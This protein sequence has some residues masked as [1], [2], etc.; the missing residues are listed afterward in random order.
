MG[1]AS[2]LFPGFR[3]ARLP[4]ADGVEI[5]ARIG[6]SGPPL[7]MLHGFPQ[8]HVMW[9]R[10][11]PALARHFTLV[12]AD[13]RGQSESGRPSSGGDAAYAKRAMA[14]DMVAVM[15][16]LGF[17]RFAA[18]GH[19]RGGR[20]LHRL[21]LD[22]PERLEWVVF[23]DI[24]PT[25]QRFRSVNM[26]MASKAYHWFFLTQPGGLPETLIGAAPE[27]FLRHTLNSWA[28]T[29]EFWD[30]R[31]FAA[32]LA[33]ISNSLALASAC[34]DY[35]A[36]ATVDLRDDEVDE[37]A[38]RRIQ[39]PSLVLWG[40]SPQSRSVS[41][42]DAWRPFAHAVTGEPIT[43]GHFL[44][45]EAPDAVLATLL[46]FLSDRLEGFGWPL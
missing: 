13:L 27:F 41:V 6:G 22:Y 15:A 1:P 24:T 32:Y 29:P 37:A 34:A 10:V 36:N 33:N 21:A 26:A 18:I 44:A 42:L 16:A 7:L 12:C 3:A 4:G 20:V 23:L 8:T 45:E 46:Q 38:G 17:W 39:A 28:L 31:A 2:D 9:H 11:A 25:L 19:D 35:R 5:F 43:A 40:A 14:A 30:H